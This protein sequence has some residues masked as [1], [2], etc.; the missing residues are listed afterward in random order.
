MYVIVDDRSLVTSGY[1][2]GFDR[3]GVSAMG[4]APGDFTDWI[5]AADDPDITAIE[6]ILLGDCA[7][8][9]SY[10]RLVKS[11]CHA[12]VI[13]MNDSNS[14]EQTLGLFAAGVDDVVRKPVHVREIMARVG[15][16][17]RRSAEPSDVAVLNDMCV[18]FDGRDPEIRG[19]TLI[20]PRRERRI[21]E[22]LVKNKGK[23]VQRAQIFNAIYGVFNEEVDECV[24]ESHISKLRKKLRQNLGHDPIDSKRFLGYMFT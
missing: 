18:Y 1:Q 23:R 24:V 21:L 6:A 10:P 9:E 22:Y 16:F 2:S 4:F 7:E 15:A 13:A 8:R 19:E 12:P 11:R 17:N 14:L 5:S 20:L 3:E